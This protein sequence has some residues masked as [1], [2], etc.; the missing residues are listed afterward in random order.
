MSTGH[1]TAC[2]RARRR[3]LATATAAGLLIALAPAAQ[4]GSITANTSAYAGDVGAPKLPVGTLAITN[5][6]AGR[7]A[8][9]FYDTDGVRD[10]GGNLDVITNIA[11]VDW[12]AARVFE[13]PLVL[14]A[15]LPYAHVI[16]AELGGA[17]V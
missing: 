6:T 5:Y 10:G 4:A 2:M 7:D 12:M 17:D 3:R 16:D 13:M 11:R 8:G 1:R 15:S 14:S 9:A